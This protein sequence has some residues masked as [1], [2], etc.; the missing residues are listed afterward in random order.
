MER[1]SIRKA[2]GKR[3]TDISLFLCWLYRIE[4]NVSAKRTRKLTLCATTSDTRLHFAGSLLCCR[5]GRVAA[6]AAARRIEEGKE[7]EEEEEEEKKT[8]GRTPTGTSAPGGGDA[9]W[10]PQRWWTWRDDAPAALSDN[11]DD[12]VRIKCGGEEGAKR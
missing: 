11:Y 8:R 12:D 3:E 5:G 10:L 7:E 4:E 1:S 6:V 2:C 9:A